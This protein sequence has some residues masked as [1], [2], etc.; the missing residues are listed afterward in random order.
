M[1]VMATIE[2]DLLCAFET[3]SVAE[4]RAIF[5]DGFDISSRI[6]GKSVVAHLLEMY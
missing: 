1:V 6:K 5:D 2:F 3:H 4:I